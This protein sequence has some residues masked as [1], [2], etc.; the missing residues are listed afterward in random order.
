MM[1]CDAEGEWE[2]SMQAAD[3]GRQ[4]RA[5]TLPVRLAGRTLTAL[6]DSGSSISMVRTSLLPSLPVI[7]MASVAC[8]HGH[9]EHCPVV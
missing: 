5:W 8:F 2:Y 4:Q 1:E 6:L 3:G 7:R 9:M